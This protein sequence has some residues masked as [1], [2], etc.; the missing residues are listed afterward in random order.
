M[1]TK[2]TDL[3]LSRDPDGAY[4]A[5]VDAPHKYDH[6]THWVWVP[7]TGNLRVWY[8]LVDVPTLRKG[9]KRRIRVTV[10]VLR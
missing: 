4:W 7:D 5:S 3:W 6:G 8:G 2:T 10:E 9:T 1:T